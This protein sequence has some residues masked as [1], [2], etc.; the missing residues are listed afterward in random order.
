MTQALDKL[1]D[2]AGVWSS[3][4]LLANDRI[5][6]WPLLQAAWAELQPLAQDRNVKVRFRSA[7]ELGNLAT[8]YG[9]ENWL[10]R[11]FMECLEA[12]VREGRPGSTV[13]IE[14]RQLG[15]RAV[16]VFH[17]SGV[18]ARA[19]REGVELAAPGRGATPRATRADPR[20]GSTSACSCAATS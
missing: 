3:G 7:G 5:E 2:L 4:S 9:S 13:V 11:V 17:D 16:V 10:R 14:H 20:H 18:F 1:V 12:A 8:L 6:L 15:P 19:V